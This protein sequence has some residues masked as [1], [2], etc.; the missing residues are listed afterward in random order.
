MYATTLFFRVFLFVV[1]CKVVLTLQSVDK[2]VVCDHLNSDIKAQAL[3]VSIFVKPNLNLYNFDSV[4]VM[5]KLTWRSWYI[6]AANL[7]NHSS[8]IV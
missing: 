3:L 1:L 2:T 7:S 6:M 5:G 8:C 4:L